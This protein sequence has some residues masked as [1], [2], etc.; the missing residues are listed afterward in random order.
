MGSWDNPVVISTLILAF[1]T[2]LLA[3]AAFWAIWQNYKLKIYDRKCQALLRI[4]NWA[5][6][7]TFLM[8]IPSPSNKAVHNFNDFVDKAENGSKSIDYSTLLNKL[9]TDF[10]EVIRT[11]TRI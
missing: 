10:W 2:I 9:L 5:E 11:S 3:I 6:K 1:V 8:T 7:C 4:R